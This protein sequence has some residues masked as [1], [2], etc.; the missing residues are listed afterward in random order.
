MRAKERRKCR[1]PN[2]Q[3]ESTKV[4]FRN[5]WAPENRTDDTFALLE[6]N[7]HGDVF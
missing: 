2:S 7:V 4:A 5:A 3:G 6:I 1:I